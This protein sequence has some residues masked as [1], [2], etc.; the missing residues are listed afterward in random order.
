MSFEDEV[1]AA[2][3]ARMLRRKVVAERTLA[4]QARIAEEKE[5]LLEFLTLARKVGIILAER[6]V[7]PEV[8]VYTSVCRRAGWFRSAETVLRSEAHFK[9]WVLDFIPHSGPSAGGKSDNFAPS[10][11]SGDQLAITTSGEIV[12]YKASFGGPPERYV[13]RGGL[14]VP[15][16]M[17][18]L[19]SHA[20][21]LD[22]VQFVDDRYPPVGSFKRFA[23]FDS[24]FG[25][26]ARLADVVLDYELEPS[27]LNP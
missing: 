6:S 25:L 11:N 17:V 16:G 9:G 27:L 26:M 18:D 24:K 15:A 13:T 4:E 8:A 1:E 3:A 19:G 10:S 7:D 23:R 22:L 20:N 12:C 2:R 5:R 14:G 21:A